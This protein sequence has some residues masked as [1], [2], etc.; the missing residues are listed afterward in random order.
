MQSYGGF[1]LIPTFFLFFVHVCCDTSGCFVTTSRNLDTVVASRAGKKKK[2]HVKHTWGLALL[3]MV[4]GIII[5]HHHP[6]HLWNR[7][8]SRER[9]PDG[10][11]VSSG[12]TPQSC[13]KRWAHRPR[14]AYQ[15]ICLR[16]LIQG[17]K[18]RHRLRSWRPHLWRCLVLK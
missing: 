6:V 4:Y 13:R 10:S 11:D 16:Q 7:S 2:P 8:C 5:G 17:C 18:W 15:P 14:P 1:Q 12:S 9:A 3:Q